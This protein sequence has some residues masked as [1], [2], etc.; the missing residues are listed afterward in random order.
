MLDISIAYNRY[1]FLGDEFLTWLWF[2]IEKEPEKISF[3]D[4]EPVSLETGNRIVLVKKIT[5]IDESVTIKGDDAGLEEGMLALR[6][7]SL[8]TELNLLLKSNNQKWRFSIKGESLNISGIKVPES[9]PVESK[10]DI[11]GAVIEKAYFYERIFIILDNLFKN[12]IK[13]RLSSEWHHSVL[14]LMKKWIKE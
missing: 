14:P 2:I 8:V 6:K 9:G 11:E 12:F 3:P 4:K 13:L 10:K 1:K 5:D 7:G